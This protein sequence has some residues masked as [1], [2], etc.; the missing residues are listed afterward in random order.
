MLDATTIITII[1][2]A[3]SFAALY[4]YYNKR[5][6]GDFLR[7]LDKRGAYAPE[8]A[9]TISETGANRIKAILLS[10]SLGDGSILRRFAECDSVSV[11]GIGARLEARY[12]L[13]PDKRETALSRYES[14]GLRFITVAVSIAIMAAFAAAACILMPYISGYLGFGDSGYVPDDTTGEITETLPEDTA[15]DGEEDGSAEQSDNVGSRYDI[16]A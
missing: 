5:I 8:T 13:V 6:V 15:E 14:K 11:G 7:M 2:L 10:L 3:A 16:A 4:T 1:F 12:Y 9:L